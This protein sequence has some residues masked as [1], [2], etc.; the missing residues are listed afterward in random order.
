MSTEPE[1]PA[2]G[3]G[4]PGASQRLPFTGSEL[5]ERAT[6]RKDRRRQRELDDGE[7]GGEA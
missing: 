1:A 4:P 7:L 3:T 6:S 2:P 5:E